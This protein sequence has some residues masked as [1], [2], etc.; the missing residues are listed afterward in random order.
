MVTAGGAVARVERLVG[1]ALIVWLSLT[2]SV[3]AQSPAPAADPASDAPPHWDL[4][5]GVSFVGTSGNS[6]T[7]S[8]GANFA[9]R[10]RH[11]PWHVEATGSALRASDNG[12]VTAAHYIGAVRGE[13]DLS[14]LLGVSLGERAERDQLAGV[15]FRNILDA[16]VSWS[17]LRSPRG[18]LDGMTGLALYHEQ[19]IAELRH[20][21]VGLL[22]LLGHVPLGPGGE[23]V[24]RI[25]CYPDVHDGSHSRLEI[26]VTVEAALN[27]HLALR[28]AD[29][30]QRSRAPVPGFKSTDN[31]LTASVEVK[32]RGMP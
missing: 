15:T 30:L 28:M 13:R 17:L 25:T 14:S 18:T 32:W 24:A 6:A 11:G 4:E 16:G 8:A 22:Q 31:T 10:H 1:P 27:S 26:E 23:T 21:P 3:L 20:H 29:L 5:L 7:S 12:E 2:G 19:A 9:Y